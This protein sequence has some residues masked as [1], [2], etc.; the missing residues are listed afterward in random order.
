MW[1]FTRRRPARPSP[2][3]VAA[4][5]HADRALIDAK[6]LDGKV[7]RAVEL[8]AEIKRVNHIALAVAKSI[9]GV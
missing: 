9:R 3:A 7:D 8:A 2:D 6:N 5:A 4:A 1:P